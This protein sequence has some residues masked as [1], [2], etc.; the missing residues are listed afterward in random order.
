[1]NCTSQLRIPVSKQW[2]QIVLQQNVAAVIQGIQGEKKK[3]GNPSRS[4]HAQQTKARHWYKGFPKCF[5]DVKD[6]LLY[7][8]DAQKVILKVSVISFHL[9][10]TCASLMVADAFKFLA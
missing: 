7:K 1:M 3:K 10:H 8:P 5:I 9:N 6:S 4:L 2:Q